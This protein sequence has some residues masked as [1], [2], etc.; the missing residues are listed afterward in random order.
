MKKY[1]IRFKFW[2]AAKVAKWDYVEEEVLSNNNVKLSMCSRNSI[3]PIV[4]SDYLSIRD[5][6]AFNGADEI[7]LNDLHTIRLE[8]PANLRRQAS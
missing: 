6:Q 5:N 2:L 3:T 7:A 1:W 4:D 8:L